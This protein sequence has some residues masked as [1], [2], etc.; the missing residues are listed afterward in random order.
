MT[1]FTWR[2]AVSVISAALVFS[3]V[4]AHAQDDSPAFWGPGPNF[5]FVSAEEFQ[6]RQPDV[7]TWAASSSGFW[8]I[9]DG[10]GCSAAVRL[11]TGALVT[12]MTVI[13]RDGEPDV[14]RNIYVSFWQHWVTEAGD[15]GSTAIT[16]FESSGAPGITSTWVDIEPDLTI[17][18]ID[19]S[20][21]QS[22]ALNF[23]SPTAGVLELRGVIIHWNR[24]ISPSPATATFPDVPTTMWAFQ[25]VEALV[26]SGIT[27]G[28][29]D[30]LYH[31]YDPVTRAQLATFLSRALGLH[32]PN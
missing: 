12:G 13:Y 32:W 23:S 21:A 8:Y 9:K 28:M 16:Y 22:Y 2:I 29:P 27:Q 26:A 7:S 25:Y 3:S 18:Y 17:K 30:G 1:R 15:A 31:P 24:Q 19:G 11:P 20:T 14:D 10:S 6:S 4:P 5:H